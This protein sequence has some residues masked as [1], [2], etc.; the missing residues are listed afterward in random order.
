M[1]QYWE[2]ISATGLAALLRR[3]EKL[4]EVVVDGQEAI[5]ALCQVI[6]QGY[7]QKVQAIKL[8][9]EGYGLSNER[10]SLLTGAL[11]ADVA[12]P[13]L[14]ME[15]TLYPGGLTKLAKARGLRHLSAS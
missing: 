15:C 8:P 1:I 14:R 6:V 13:A 2:D 12:L 3:Q 10:L 7:C 9:W 4:V 5:P 11:E